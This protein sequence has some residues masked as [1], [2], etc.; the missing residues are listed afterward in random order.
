M[1]FHTQ[2]G[3]IAGGGGTRGT[4]VRTTNYR[5]G[6][7]LTTMTV[8]IAAGS[9]LPVP[10]FGQA[11]A[12]R[13]LSDVRVENVGTCSTL[14]INF[15]IRIQMLSYFPTE[16]GREV[17][18]RV[19]PLDPGANSVLRESLR[20]PE[21]VKAL[22]SITYEGDNPSGPVLSLYFTRDMRFEVEPG[23]EPQSLV[24]RLSEA[25]KPLACEAPHVQPGSRAPT[26]GHAIPAGLYVIN[27]VS[28]PESIAT[29][30]DEQ[31]VLLR[32]RV[33]YETL[34]ERESQQ[35]H[36]LREGFFPTRAEAEAERTRLA[37]IFPEAFVVK[38][39]A[40]ERAQGVASRVDNSEPQ[41]TPAQVPVASEA[42]TIATSQLIADAEIAIRDG[43][44]DRA[45]A[46]LTNALQKPENAHTARALELLGLTRERKGQSAQA[47]AEY[48]EYLRRYPV[49]E[50]ADRVRQRLAALNGPTQAPGQL[51]QASGMK[52]ASD[53]TWGVRGSFSQFYFRDQS[54]TKFVDATQPEVG[55]EVD[56][57]VN[58]NQL[59]T[60][61][62]IT[63]SG[64]NDRRQVEMRAAGSH[65]W[66]FR[67]GG[68]DID[69]LTALYADYSDSVANASARLGR[70]TRNTSG[71]LGRF[72]G[73][74]LG[75]QAQ[76]KLRVNAVAGFP[77]LTSRQ[78][79]VL[80]DRQFYGVSVDIGSKRSPVQT[81]LYWF[82]QH[83]KGGFID[84]RSAGIEA[85]LL[86]S[87][88]NAFT[89]VDYDVKFRK[90]NLGLLT[91]N[92]AFPDAS[93][94]SLTADY[95][96]S[97]L[98]T[99]SNALI[100]QINT[101]TLSP[102][103]DLRG[104]RPFFTDSDIYQLADDRTLVT[105]SL[106]MSYS[107]PISKKLQASV[108][109]TLNH[110]GGTRGTPATAGTGEVFALPSS[111][112]EYYYGAQLVGSGLLWSN[113]IYILSGR[114]SDTQRAKS[115]TAD[116]NAR[117]PI[118]AKFRLNPR[119][120]YGS[121]TDKLAASDFKQFQPTL[122]MNWYPVNHSEVE[123][124]LGG[125]FSRQRDVIA[126]AK[127]TTRE[128]GVVLTAGYRIDF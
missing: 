25:G 74:L 82:D 13:T 33:L 79:N 48:Q 88:F 4:R 95:R 58:L 111:G 86:L 27:L 125:N 55:A 11:V 40:D 9:A 99:T 43:A 128:S 97:P 108:D 19:R 107:R 8:A 102:I 76:P 94:I 3:Q 84:R 101:I 114:Y 90:L 59:L 1:P 87:R 35:W 22:R 112:T 56:N 5:T 89:I 54:T 50:A 16:D 57:A 71:V 17:H 115:W 49:G 81:T 113:D 122:R 118:S 65:T 12:D 104:L 51:R 116:L 28:R 98:L 6:A 83:A 63:I 44:N 26:A 23:R 78:M 37:T 124:E 20:T 126:G 52:S 68:Q 24:I 103:N 38:I 36:R 119:L 109:F 14:T 30:S 120:R 67:K 34:F 53:W 127:M 31:K 117:V 32:G 64:G 61:G 73:L 2:L 75:W 21:S 121:R 39:S 46:L 42:D 10:A 72:D 93:N 29:L 106:T 77:V 66:N 62:D 60:S 92:Y 15:N 105:K 80:K 45:V 7:A 41:P 85:R 123:I 91:L 18:V 100:G 69:T 47:Q 70:Q 110:S 96:Q